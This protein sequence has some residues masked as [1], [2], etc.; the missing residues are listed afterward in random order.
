[1][2]RSAGDP[3][4]AMAGHHLLVW[5]STYLEALPS[6]LLDS[7]PLYVVKLIPGLK[8]LHDNDFC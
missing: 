7:F 5:M 3:A 2:R 1:M 4:L 6:Q 8:Y